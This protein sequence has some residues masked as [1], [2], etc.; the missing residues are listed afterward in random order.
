MMKDNKI[1][2]SKL[3]DRIVEQVYETAFPNVLTRELR[4]K[5]INEKIER[6]RLERESLKKANVLA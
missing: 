5:L 2:Y 6:A 3:N 1:D 4:T